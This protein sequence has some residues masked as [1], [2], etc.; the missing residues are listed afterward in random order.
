MGVK[1][2]KTNL[3]NRRNR[4]L[5]FA[6]NSEGYD[7]TDDNPTVEKCTTQTY[8]FQISRYKGRVTVGG[9][10]FSPMI[11]GIVGQVGTTNNGGY[12]ES[13]H[14]RVI[15]VEGGSAAHRQGVTTQMFVKSMALVHRDMLHERRG[16]PV[17]I[18]ASQFRVARTDLEKDGDIWRGQEDAVVHNTLDLEGIMS[19]VESILSTAILLKKSVQLE[20]LWYKS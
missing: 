5:S 7:L 15:R 13:F 6:L 19:Q 18:G 4:V 9:I 10:T 1:T 14:V 12:L 8:T 16:E 20:L 17:L 3:S 2:F 11:G